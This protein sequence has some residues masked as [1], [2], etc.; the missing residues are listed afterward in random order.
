MKQTQAAALNKLQKDH[1]RT[2]EQNKQTRED[3]NNRHANSN[4]SIRT[5]SRKRRNPGKPVPAA[6]DNKQETNNDDDLDLYGQAP[7]NKRRK[8]NG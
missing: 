5:N 6:D 1:A 8:Q 3:Y 2:F 4:S 7:P